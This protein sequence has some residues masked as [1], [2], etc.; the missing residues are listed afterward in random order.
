MASDVFTQLNLDACP[1]RARPCN[2]QWSRCPYCPRARAPHEQSTAGH[3]LQT[4]SELNLECFCRF[5]TWDGRVRG[6]YW[7]VHV[8]SFDDTLILLL[9]Q[10]LILYYRIEHWI[11]SAT[12]YSACSV[13]PGNPQDLAV[14]VSQ[15]T[16]TAPPELLVPYELAYLTTSSQR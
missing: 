11:S 6:R 10:L 13:E 2:A 15:R 16:V 5:R 14:I 7:Y 1:N 3:D 12:Q 9:I 4:Y 8:S